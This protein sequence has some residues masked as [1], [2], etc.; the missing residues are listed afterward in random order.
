MQTSILTWLQK[1]VQTIGPPT[2]A[3]LL[4][5][6]SLQISYLVFHTLAELFSIIIAATALV[7]AIT[8]RHFTRNQFVVYISIAMGWCAGLDFVH[9]LTYEG[10]QL[11]PNGGA[12]LTTQVWIAARFIQAAAL[13]SAPLLLRRPLQLVWIFLAYGAICLAALLLIWKG[14]MPDAFVVG[15]GLT[16]FKIVMEYVIIAMLTLTLALLWQQRSLISRPL[17][18]ALSAALICMII[19]EFA[20]TRYASPFGAANALG[21]IFKIYAY[22]FI[23]LALVQSTLREPFSMLTRAASTYDA[24]PDPTLIISASG[25]IHQANKAAAE[26]TGQPAE[27]LVGQRA[28]ALFHD[29]GVTPDDC[30]ICARTLLEPDA[31]FTLELT[32]ED[33]S[34]VIEC[35]VAPFLDNKSASSYVLVVHDVTHRYVAQR[36][37]Q[38][39]SYLYEMLS[40][41]NHAIVGC[42]DEKALLSSIFEA[43]IAHG[44]FP[45]LFIALTTDGHPPLR[46]QYIQGIDDGH[47]PLLQAVL[48]QN[49]GVFTQNHTTLA[50]GEV[51]CKAVTDPSTTGE[52]LPRAYDAWDSYLCAA[53]IQHR[54]GIPMLRHGQIYGVIVLYQVDH[55]E[56][57]GEQL[58]L[59][60]EMSSDI[61]FALENM[62]SEARRLAAE[63][64][65]DA[66]EHR[67]RELFNPSPLPMQIHSLSTLEMTALN[68]AHSHFLGYTLEEI[69]TDELWFSNAF[70]DRILH[71]QRMEVWWQSVELAKTGQA[72]SSPELT[73]HC[74]DGSTRVAIGTMTL[75]GDDILIAWT[76][77]TE[78]RR[79][80]Q[81]LRESEQRFRS[82]IE[83]TG[84]G[85]YIRRDGRYIY[86]NPSYCQIVGW[87]AEQL[88]GEEVLRF[89]DP[90]D[91]EQL[92]RIRNAWTELHTGAQQSA[93]YEVSTIRGDGSHIELG[94]H[95]KLLTWEDG[96]PATI[97]IVNDISERKR[98]EAQIAAY[99]LQ[100]EGSMKGTLQAVSNMVELRDPYTAGHERRVGII[101]E[102]IALQMGWSPERG[103][104]LE[105]VGLVHDIGKIAVPSEILSKPSRLSPMEMELVKLH[106]QAGYDILKDV[107]FPVPVA[108]IIRQHHERM[109]GSGYPRGLKG[110][111]IMPEARVLAVAD[112][113]ESM[114]AHRPYRPALGIDV[115]LAEIESGSGTLYDPEVVQ[116]TL[117]LIREQGYKLPE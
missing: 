67:F 54:A 4:S 40:A 116:A 103:E 50:R 68:L 87:T 47:R 75:V 29:Y 98:N 9:A 5:L 65:A 95:T 35:S 59:L 43:L 73:L 58:A 81:T 66:S 6:L 84:S 76:D 22:W 89:V 26:F 20:F 86:V 12:N 100:L 80:E 17:L 60:N 91:K 37:I 61:S 69:K 53:G 112:V 57:D 3:V 62:S 48:E 34:R 63:R 14:F 113:L 25:H 93:S 85:V 10:M 23:Y 109:D 39:L 96:Q 74:K 52:E 45:K 28:H 41:I 38:R 16:T 90:E 2:V 71:E 106:P 115:A 42:K 32:R 44:T 111:E 99:V 56:F 88:V 114:S 107:P 31:P 108:E 83:Q 36:R 7:V 13:L 15:R 79:N 11:F 18:L 104:T 105:L 21:H 49:D 24:I 110:D 8:A 72:V 70:P 1:A 94:L 117:R 55:A 51:V 77:L 64:E 46:L 78:I 33:G 30:P 101:A 19:S 92:E 27:T 102:Q 97:V 82:M